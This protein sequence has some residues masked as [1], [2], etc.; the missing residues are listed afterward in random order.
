M[1]E[2]CGKIDPSSREFVDR[3]F[4]EN[5]P[6]SGSLELTHRCN[7][8]C[9]HCYQFSPRS[10]GELD[11]GQWKKVLEDLAA[12]GCLFLAITGGE[13]LLREDLPELIDAAASRGYALTLQTNGVLLD[14]ATARLL[15][16]YPT[17]RV[18]VSVYGAKTSTHD[19]FTG[20]DGSLAAARRAMELLRENG[21]PLMLKATVG[22]FNLDE[23]EGIAALADSLGVK[24][25]FSSLI[26][27]CND[28]GTAPTALRLD[29]AGLERFI[30]FET[31][32]MREN[33]CELMGVD[34]TGL[35]YE[36]MAAFLHKCAVDPAQIQG[37]SR[38]HCG[39]GSTVFA[40][41]PYGDVYP[42]VAFPLVVGNVIKD[43]FTDI[44]KDSPEL[45]RLRGLED[46]LP[47]HCRDC[48]L[49]DKC[50]FCRALSF[51]EEGDMMAFNKERCRQTRTL[52]KVLMHEEAHS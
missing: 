42:C 38:H 28:R 35:S 40:I 45:I 50:A 37:E 3:I 51:L 24:A 36:D 46:D 52:V 27:P 47:E 19:G 10:G 13:P 6:Y 23:V 44:W 26:F 31:S 30:R 15:G 43:N 33:I 29:D 11:T 17:L 9:R 5:I 25:V 22:G 16:R 41:N 32:Y 21:V 39:G 2:R 4:R 14:A 8:S 7:L 12:A 49:L 18:D 1:R 34:A 48:V 20:M